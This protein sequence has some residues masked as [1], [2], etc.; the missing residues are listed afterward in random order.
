MIISDSS[1][2]V[3]LLNNNTYKMFATAALMNE[4]L[5]EREE[6]LGVW[7]FKSQIKMI[8]NGEVQPMCIVRRKGALELFGVYLTAVQHAREKEYLH[9]QN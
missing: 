3:V 9:D 7:K 1:V 2:W 8:V 4:W 6:S 5:A